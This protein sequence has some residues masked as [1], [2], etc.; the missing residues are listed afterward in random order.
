MVVPVV[1]EPARVYRAA[2]AKQDNEAQ[3]WCASCYD[4]VANDR[5]RFLINGADEFSFSN[6][7]GMRFEIITF[8][9]TLGCRQCGAPTLADTWFPGCAWCYCLCAGCGQHLGWYYSGVREFAG[10]I[11]S[12]LVRALG[13]RN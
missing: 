8:E 11:R 7:A 1:L 3:W 13:F 5:H 6:P 12:R 10:L 4:P 9:Q 2:D